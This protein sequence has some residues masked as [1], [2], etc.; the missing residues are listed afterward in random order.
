MSKFFKYQSLGNDYIVIDPKYWKLP[1]S[2]RLIKTICDRHFGIG[3]NGILYGPLYENKG[4]N[5]PLVKIY[6][7][8]GSEA[9][10]SG[11]GARIFGKYLYDQRYV[12]SKEFSFR[13]I[14]GI[15]NVDIN[16]NNATEMCISLGKLQFNPRKD[17]KNV[18]IK[19]K[20]YSFNIAS[21]GNPHCVIILPK[22]SVNFAKRLGP[23]IEY[24]ELFPN[25]TNVQFVKII[26]RNTIQIEIW[27]RG[28]G[29]TLASGTSSAAAA[30]VCYKLGLCHNTIKVIM[31]GGKV[32]V[33]IKPSLEIFQTG[34][35][36]KIYDG[37]VSNEFIESIFYK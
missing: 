12:S 16:N 5:I 18:V 26:D 7:P 33:T 9:E 8:D 24:Q 28:A 31:P 35:V 3:S 32:Q 10:K 30:G 11:N 6:N 22:I 36:H 2:P 34:E 17:I 14:S 23:L 21:I 20:K 27:E 29:Y 13:T 19:N 1:L 4:K 25:R 15:V 37:F